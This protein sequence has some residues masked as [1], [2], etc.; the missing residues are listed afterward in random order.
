MTVRRA[1][2]R[3]E[4]RSVR[5]AAAVACE[6]WTAS[7]SSAGFLAP[8]FALA[9]RREKGCANTGPSTPLFRSRGALC[10]AVR[11]RS[12]KDMIYRV[13]FDAFDRGA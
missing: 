1:R 9:L 2:F 13:R 5:R 12:A 10:H 7:F 8:R 6:G 4:W 3:D 11:C